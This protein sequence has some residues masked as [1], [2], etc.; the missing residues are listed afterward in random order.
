MGNLP[1]FPQFIFSPSPEAPGWMH[2]LWLVRST[3]GDAPL[4]I[5]F[6]SFLFVALVLV[7]CLASPKS[8][9]KMKDLQR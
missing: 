7:Q 3:P 1:G 4:Y 6:V 8:L 2:T 5:P 9:N